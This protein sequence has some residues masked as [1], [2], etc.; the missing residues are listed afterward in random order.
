M[1]KLGLIRKIDKLGR[2]VLPR[3]LRRTLD[4]NVG[5]PIEFFADDR[6]IIIKKYNPG[7]LSCGELGV[8]MKEV[9]G[10]RLCKECLKRF[11]E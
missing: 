2:L 9:N 7:C 1:K 3:E 10:I 6:S 11:T 8:N 5:D 4:M